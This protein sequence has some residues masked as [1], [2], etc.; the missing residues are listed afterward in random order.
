ML[1]SISV[2]SIDKALSADISKCGSEEASIKEK[3]V[4]QNF[5]SKINV[6]VLD[7]NNNIGEEKKSNS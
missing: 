4:H 1:S 3:N 6:E 2:G 7:Q 5:Q